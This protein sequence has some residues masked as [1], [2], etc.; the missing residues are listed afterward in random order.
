M[1]PLQTKLAR[2]ALGLRDDQKRSYR[3]RYVTGSGGTHYRTWM[4]MVRDGNA[5]REAI[6]TADDKWLFSL[7]PAGA[8]AAIRKGESLDP[9]DFPNPKRVR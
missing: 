3:N 1:T 2:H 5:K 4:R 9:E 8:L 7:T 6:G